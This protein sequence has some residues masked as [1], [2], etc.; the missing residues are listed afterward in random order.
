MKRA[1]SYMTLRELYEQVGVDVD[2]VF[3]PDAQA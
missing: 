3:L 1:G 2:A